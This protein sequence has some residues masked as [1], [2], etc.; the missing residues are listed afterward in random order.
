[1]NNVLIIDL[2]LYI[3]DDDNLESEDFVNSIKKRIKKHKSISDKKY[4]LIRLDYA[5]PTALAPKDLS[6]I[7]N[8]LSDITHS[9][10]IISDGEQ[11]KNTQ[12]IDAFR[13]TLNNETILK[14]TIVISLFGPEII[15]NKAVKVK[16]NDVIKGATNIGMSD[17]KVDFKITITK[18]ALINIQ[19]FSPWFS[20]IVDETPNYIRV[21]IPKY[22][23]EDLPS[24]M[25][26]VG[27]MKDLGFIN[28]KFINTSDKV[29]FY[30]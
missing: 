12:Y 6:N 9:L 4:N 16:Y 27:M 28:D 7:L 10:E 3:D 2:S 22:I 24:L 21:E 26:V 13:N 23:K 1:M 17:I 30:A 20:S 19:D 29:T 25:L 18:R 8:M 11:F 15:H 5:E 14:L